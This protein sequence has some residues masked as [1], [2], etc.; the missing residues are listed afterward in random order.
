MNEFLQGFIY[1]REAFLISEI[2]EAKDGAIHGRMLPGL[3]LLVAPHQRGEEHLHPRHVSGPDL[4]LVTACLGCLHAYFFHGLRWQ[5]K[6]VGFGSRMR[7]VQ[8]R[9]LANL[10]DP[11]ELFSKETRARIKPDRALLEFN[12][13]FLQ[14]GKVVYQSE[15]SAMFVRD[16]PFIKGEA[17][18]GPGTSRTIDSTRSSRDPLPR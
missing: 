1:S 15:Q 5:E 2:V 7:N 10:K 17:G 16:K 12:F 14:N 11:V 9:D 6:W 18:H 13:R 8:F 3:P 4:I